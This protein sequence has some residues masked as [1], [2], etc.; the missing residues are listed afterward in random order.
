MKFQPD[1]PEG[2]NIIH[3][4]TRTQVSVNGQPHTS[5][6]LVPGHAPLTAWAP[7]TMEELTANH[8]AEILPFKPEL[9]ILGSGPALRFAHPSVLRPLID[10][11]IGVETMD[12]PAACRTYNVLMSE[13]RKVLAAL[14]IHP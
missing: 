4:V 7:A 1:L 2:T 10:A 12:T 13:G 3:A 11:G 6:V 8:I 5:S 14:I 9:V